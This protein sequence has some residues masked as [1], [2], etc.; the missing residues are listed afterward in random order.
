[1]PDKDT[2]TTIKMPQD[3]T[4]SQVDEIKRLIVSMSATDVIAGLH[5]AY[6]RRSAKDA[7]ELKVGRK[8][9]IQNEVHSVTI[10]QAQWRLA[11]WKEMIAEYRRKGYS[12]PSISR[13]KKLLREK[14][15]SN[16]SENHVTSITHD[17]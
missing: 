17:T 13:I 10:E 15:K 5:F 1:M 3:A 14:A 16:E 2:T 11:N 6:K 4:E 12:Y 7:G 8:S 9:M